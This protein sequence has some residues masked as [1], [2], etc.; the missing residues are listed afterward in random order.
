M[1]NIFKMAMVALVCV[2]VNGHAKTQAIIS[3]TDDKPFTVSA[4]GKFDM[5]G[6]NI[7]K[8][9]SGMG[10]KSL[11]GNLGFSHYV[12]HNFEYG[13]NV[14]GGWATSLRGKLFAQEGKLDGF[15]TGVNLSARYL[16]EVG[17]GVSL[18]GIAGVGYSRLFGEGD[19]GMHDSF[20]FGDTN[21]E[22]GPS[23]MHRANDMFAWGFGLTY[24]MTEMRFGGEKAHEHAKQYSNLHTLRLPIDFVVQA[25][26]NL[27]VT[28]ALEPG[29]RHLGKDSKFHQG[30][31]YDVAAGV[32][33][34]L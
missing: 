24:G 23:F 10:I 26:D 30:L 17:S 11:A 32:N 15:K 5:G 4:S 20:S 9:D 18:G 33:F 16:R 34:S 1:R 22:V 13:V 2:A 25:T 31:F 28:L 27:G 19:K 21:F 29:W 7:S 6:Y 3:G 14:F 12:G 8:D